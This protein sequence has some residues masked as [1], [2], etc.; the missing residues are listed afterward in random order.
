MSAPPF[1]SRPDSIIPVM[2]K[3]L[4]LLSIIDTL[5]CLTRLG[6]DV[7]IVCLH[8]MP[9]LFPP[10]ELPGTSQRLMSSVAPRK[11]TELIPADAAPRL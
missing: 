8:T 3:T 10:L 2:L 9:T 6:P 1:V 11:V 4:A 7:V 5:L